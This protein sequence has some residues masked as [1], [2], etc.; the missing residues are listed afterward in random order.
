V[1]SMMLVILSS[2]GSALGQDPRRT[3]PRV[4]EAADACA[5]RRTCIINPVF[6]TGMRCDGLTDDSAAL[7]AA[8][9]SAAYPGLGNA[10]VIM[11]P[12]TCIIDPA[13]SVRISSS[14]WLQG[15]GRFGTTLKRKNSSTG[16]QMLIISSDGITLS[17]FAFDGNKGGTGIAT[18]SDSV[19]ADR[20]LSRVTI[21]RMRFANSTNS[22]IASYVNGAGNFPTDWLITDSEFDNQGNPFSDCAISFACANLFIQQP[23][24]LRII[25]NRSDSSQNFA[26]F[27]SYPGGGQVDVGQNIITNIEGF[28]VALGGGVLGSAGA[29]IHDNFIV[30]SPIEQDNL[31]DLAFWSD[32]TVDHNFMHYTGGFPSSIGLPTG[33]VGDAPPANHGEVDANTCYLSPILS[34]NVIGISLGGN[35][36]SITNNFVQGATTAGISVDVFTE[37]PSKGVRV[38]GNTTK[39]NSQ[40]TPGA[41]AGIGLYLQP[42]GPNLAAISDVIIRGNHSYDDQPVK[43]QGYG[44]GIAL[45]GQTTGYSNI[46][47]EGND[48]AGNLHGGILN[49]ASSF[50]GFVIRNNLGHNPAGVITAPAFPASGASAQIN[51]TGYDVTLYIT[52][53]TNPITIAINGT[54]LTG[55]SV[56]GGGAVSGPIRLPANQN[57]TLTYTGGGTP[58]W[59]WIAD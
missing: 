1:L 26:F 58:S 3:P 46:I 33:C 44:I 22:D 28:G 29:H 53:G 16:S 12:G 14:I 39:N 18:P 21:Q 20:A 38:I 49:N 32:F 25:G 19:S 57:I 11:P 31:V 42:G 45:A 17:D 10:T 9:T 24:R 34:T 6:A 35:D 56:A 47:M 27:R 40:Q 37:A 23:L 41:N 54:T 50:T 4:S 55:I 2:L 52:S 48:L 13:A 15:A 8:L 5:I 43:T 7:Q 51:G 30:S 59:Q 36:I